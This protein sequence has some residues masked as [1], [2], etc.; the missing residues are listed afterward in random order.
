MSLAL[1]ALLAAA[2][3]AADTLDPRVPTPRAVLGYEIGEYHTS[4]L[5]VMRYVEALAREVPDRVAL[6]PIGESYERRPMV[7]LVISSPENMRRLDQVKGDLAR[8]TDPRRTSDAE[9]DEI[10][11]R[12]PAVTWDNFGND[13]N[14]S[15][16]VEAA[17]L[18]AYR[19]AASR[20]GEVA[21][22]LQQVVAVLN[23]CHNPESRE[24][25]VA[26]YNSVQ[27]GPHGT[28]DPQAVEHSGP[29]GMDTNNN[30]YQTDLNRD[31]VWATQQ[32]TRNVIRA[33]QEW[34]PQTFIDHHGETENFFFPP[35]ALPVN[36]NLPKFHLDWLE[37]YGRAIAEA[38]DRRSWS[39]F[40]GETFDQFYPGYWDAYPFFKG[41]I[42][43]TFETN[44]GGYTGLQMERDDETIVTLRDGVDRHV[45]GGLAVLLTT[46][47]H[48]EK[49]LRD[50]WRYRKTALE[51]GRTGPTRAYV[52]AP[53]S[54]PGRAAEAVAT[55][56]FHGVEVRRTTAA[57]TLRARDYLT[58]ELRPRTI[59]AGS[60]VVPLDQPEKRLIQAILEPRTDQ[61][62]E[63]LS[64]E[65]EKRAWNRG[66][67]RNVPP[68]RNAFYDVTAWALPYAYA[69]E[70]YAVEEPVPG[71]EPLAAP[72]LV[73]GGIAGGPAR[74]AYLFDPRTLGS[75]RLALALL[76]EEFRVAVARKAF[77]SGG[78]AWPR[79]T[80]V[81]RVERNPPSLAERL[82]PLAA[83]SG[84]EV[85]AVQSAWTEQ[86]IDLGSANIDSLE[87][88]R[89]AVLADEPTDETA[90]GAIWF[91]LERRLGQP[92]TALRAQDLAS[93]E[94]DRYNA[95]V[96]P[97][98]PAG[99]YRERIGEKGLERLARWVEDGGALVLTGGAAAL[100]VHDKVKWSKARLLGPP[101]DKDEDEDG[102]EKD[103][104]TEEHDK[105]SSRTPP[106]REPGVSSTSRDELETETDLRRQAAR[107]EKET[108]LTPGAIFAA[109]L[110]P[111][112]FLTY[113]CGDGPLPVL[114]ASS[115][116]F[117]ASPSGVN[118]AR[119]RRERPRLSGFAWPEAESRLRGAAY[120]IDE[121]RER[122]HVILFAD[123]PNFRNFWRGLEK[124][125]TNAI[126][127]GPSL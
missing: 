120:L 27:V 28:P 42:G 63:F 113:G 13:G 53:G 68:D 7:L 110:E 107:R 73:R 50:Y 6:V 93:A 91:L 20:D 15:A 34:N 51:E 105:E 75:T 44:A 1:A 66:R 112:H 57:L 41:A 97:D 125:F 94:L 24:R 79:G 69:L 3:L 4:Y 99:E 58:L 10:I 48:R 29:W 18:M 61:Q 122:G 32:E 90:Y 117:S 23:V 89:V 100:A 116:V 98:G 35:V 108:E 123:D 102:E 14:E 64:E 104:E 95:I 115:N 46:A 31:S 77:A 101:P 56:M 11:R 49:K 26:W 70:A 80:F 87:P 60:Y 59:P 83:D 111:R 37:T 43:F 39:Y 96:L 103:R 84:V 71:G 38:S 74:S 54:D 33:Y 22:A 25:F 78:R 45:E 47:A 8:L 62:A 16:A 55:L 88:P 118:V 114:V 36:P 109:D 126:L 81:V 106:A 5:G 67:G 2:P 12:T 72:P 52:V 9:A 65:R 21:Q 30:H 124:L 76:R 92:F 119:I 85:L 19:L 127:L 17:L 86:G 82:G 121:P 40:T